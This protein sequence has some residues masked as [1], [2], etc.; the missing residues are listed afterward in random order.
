MNNRTNQQNLRK[1]EKLREITYE[2]RNYFN[3]KSRCTDKNTK[4]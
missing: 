4:K 2:K 1:T 3:A